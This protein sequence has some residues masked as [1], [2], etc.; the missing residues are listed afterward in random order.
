MALPVADS[1]LNP[2]A[3]Q[4]LQSSRNSA[5]RMS[6]RGTPKFKPL[7][8]PSGSH[9]SEANFI[10]SQTTVPDDSFAVFASVPLSTTDFSE[11]RPSQL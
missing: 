11:L 8:P 9:L 1:A 7:L 4:R 10:A 3:G 2:D 6:C 5:G